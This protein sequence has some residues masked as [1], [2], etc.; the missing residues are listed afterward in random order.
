MILLIALAVLFVALANGA[1]D[2]FKGVATL[3][4]SGTLG[5][6]PL[7]SARRAFRVGEQT[8]V[9][10]GDVEELASYVPGAGTVR[11]ASGIAVAVDQLD[12][13]E[14]RYAG[15]VFGFDAQGALDRL[16]L[17]AAGAVGF[18][19]GLNDPPKI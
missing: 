16:H 9:C 18:A 1:N 13:C 14:R 17:L 5:Y 4:G 11:L 3:H 12:R 19:R 6:R 7:R 8:C 2:N 15:R 10:I